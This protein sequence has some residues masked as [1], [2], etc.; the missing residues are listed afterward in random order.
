MNVETKAVRNQIPTYEPMDPVYGVVTFLCLIV[1]F[2]VYAVFKSNQK[3]KVEAHNAAVHKR[4]D[5]VL[6]EL[7]KYNK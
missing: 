7:E 4:M 6:A 3:K 2:V 1:P 5:G